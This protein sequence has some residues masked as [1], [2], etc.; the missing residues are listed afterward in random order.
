MHFAVG[1]PTY[2]KSIHND[3]RNEGPNRVSI[4]MTLS[5]MYTVKISRDFTDNHSD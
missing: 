1:Y 3:A 5:V 2:L 4:N